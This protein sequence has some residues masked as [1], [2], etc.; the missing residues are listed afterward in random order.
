ME[1]KQLEQLSGTVEEITFR[2]VENGFTVLDLNS[3]GELVTVV[4]VLPDVSAGEELRLMGEWGF[5]QVFGRQFK[6]ELCER[7]LP[8]NSASMLKYLSSGAVKGI[9]PATAEKIVAEFGDDT[10]EVLEN[11]PDKL[12]RIKGISKDKAKLISENF[13]K[14]FAVR[15][16]M[17]YL[18]G[19]GM[20]PSECLK[21]YKA[22]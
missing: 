14:Q 20:T 11:H 15:Q 5:H 8:A 7:F 1:E 12:A 13:K 16:V 21:A 9:G 19:F 22:L 6:A 18:E 2:K 17:I 4:G 10:F 3:D